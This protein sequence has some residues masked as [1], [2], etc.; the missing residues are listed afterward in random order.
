L[1]FTFL[2]DGEEDAV[3]WTYGMLQRQARVI[4]ARIQSS[5]PIDGPVLLLYP[6]GLDFIAAFAGC[7]HAG[8]IAVPAYPPRASRNLLRLKT[9]AFDSRARV[10][11]TTRQTLRRMQQLFKDDSQLG[12]LE[13]ICT[14]ELSHDL[15]AHWKQPA[16]SGDST[17]FLQYTSGSTSEPKGVAVSHSNLLCNEALIRSAFRQERRSVI[18]GWLPLYHDMGLI[19]NVFQPLYAAARAILMSPVAFVQRPVRWLRAISRYRAT[20]SGGPNFSYDL[21]TRR[22][23]QEEES[24]LDLSNW[25]VAFNGAEPVRSDTLNRFA[26]RFGKIGFNPKAFVPCYGLAE[27][28]LMVSGQTRGGPRTLCLDANALACNEVERTSSKKGITIVGCGKKVPRSKLAIVD[29]ES[30]TRCSPNR[31]GEI[32]IA[33]PS[34]AQGYWNRDEESQRTF[35]ARIAN[36]GE[37]PFLRTGDLGFINKDELFITGRLKDLI[38]I[39]GR[40]HYPRDIE[41]TV[42]AAHASLRPGCGAAFSVEANGE[43]QLVIVQ[44]V[45]H[46]HA[47]KTE[48]AVDAICIALMEQHEIQIHAI[49]LIRSG[50]IAKTSSGKIQRY[51]CREQFLAGTLN[52]ILEWRAS[53]GMDASSVISTPTTSVE[54]EV[55]LVE[56]LAR[57]AGVKPADIQSDVAMARYGLDSLGAIEFVY[58]IERELNIEVSS[59]SLL[60]GSSIHDYAE[61]LWRQVLSKGRSTAKN[62]EVKEAD[63]AEQFALTQNQRSLWFVHHL[64][65]GSAAYNLAF[66]ARTSAQLNSRIFEN[67]LREVVDRHPSL[68]TTFHQAKEEVI[69]RVHQTTETFVR[70]IDATSWSDADLNRQL[71]EEAAFQFNLEQGPLLRVALFQCAGSVSVICL[72]LHHIIADL[73]SLALLMHELT[74]LY[75]AKIAARPLQLPLPG[76]NYRDYAKWQKEEVLSAAQEEQLFSYWSRELGGELTILNLPT[77]QPRPPVQTYA[78]ARRSFR[79]SAELSQRIKRLSQEK[80][81]TPYMTLLATFQVLLS[82]YSGQQDILIGSPAAARNRVRWSEVVGYFVNP[83]VLRARLH[84][85][86]AFSEF[87]TQVRTAVLGALENQDYP[88]LNLVQRLQIE[89]DPSRSPLFQAM[90]VFE[91][92]LFLEKEGISAFALAETG[93]QVEFNG[94]ALEPIPL[95]NR[96]ALFDL[97]LM[98]SEIKGAFCGSF[99][100]NTDLF[101]EET[102]TRMVQHL[103]QLLLA[104]V[105]SPETTVGHLPMLTEAEQKQVLEQMNGMEE[106][107]SPLCIQEMFQLQVEQRP[108]AIAV[109]FEEQSL[110]YQELNSRANQLGHFLRGCGID[111]E[112]P[113]A[114]CCA[115][116][117]E[118]I[119]G[120]SGIL[121]AGGVHVPLD[122]AYPADRL[123]WML[124]DTEAP[125]LLTGQQT[126]LKFSETPC[127]RLRLDT[128]WKKITDA[129]TANPPPSAVPKNLAYIIYTSGSTG[130]PKGVAVS[131]AGI[132]AL[133]ETQRQNLG[134]GP[135]SRVLQFSSVSFDACI[136]EIV[137][138][139]TS[140]AALIVRPEDARG[141]RVLQDEM[142]RQ[143]VTHATL[144]P[145]VLGTLEQGDNL[146]SQCLIVAGEPCS[147][148][149]ASRWSKHR[150]MVNAYGPTET[151]VCATMSG[152]LSAERIPPIGSPILNTEVYVLD[153]RMEAVPVGIHG[154]L[155]IGGISL[156][157]GYL[158]QPQLTAEKFVPSP[159]RKEEGARLYRTGDLGR[160]RSDGNLEFIGRVDEQVK[161]RGHRVEPGEIESALLGNKGVRQ[162]VVVVREESGEKRLVAYWVRRGEGQGPSVRQLR[163]HLGE[164]LPD[165]MIPSAFVRLEDLPLTPNGK[166]DRKRLPAPECGAGEGSSRVASHTPVEEIMAGIWAEVLKVESVSAEADFFELGGHSLLAMQVMLRTR[167]AFGVNLPLAALFEAPTVQELAKRVEAGLRQGGKAE[168]PEIVPVSSEMP[169]P[170]SFAQQRLWFLHQVDPQ[171]IAYNGASALR[172]NGVL[173]VAALERAMSEIVRRHETL[174]TIFPAADGQPV[175]RI[176]PFT[177]LSVPLV[178]LSH[179]SEKELAARAVAD[180]EAERAFDLAQGP[181]L[182]IRLVRLTPDDHLLLV[183]MHHI[184]SDG[185][186]IGI[187]IREFT[188]L[189]EAFLQGQPSPLEDLAIQYADFAHWQREWMTGEVLEAQLAFW[190]GQLSGMEQLELPADYPRPVAALG[191]G[192]RLGIQIDAELKRRLEDVSRQQGVTLFMTLM[193]GFQLLL[194]RY[195]GQADVTVGTAIANRTCVETEPLIGFFVNTLVLRSCLRMEESFLDLLGQV[196]RTVLDAYAHQNL[197]FDRLV[198]ELAPERMLGQT[199]LFQA[200]LVLQNTPREQLRLPGLTL[201][202]WD[203]GLTA[204]TIDLRLAFTPT[205]TGLE[206]TLEYA[207]D[208]F[209]PERME[210]LARHF[211]KLLERAIG[212]PETRLWEISLLDEPE[213]RQVVE[214][215]NQTAMECPAGCV[216]NMFET[217]VET[218]PGDVALVFGDN[219]LTYAELNRRANRMAH[220]LRRLGIGPEVRV[221]ISLDRSLEIMVAILAVLKAGGAYVP[222]DPRYPTERLAYMLEDAGVPVLLTQERVAAT[223]PA[224]WCQ[225]LCVESLAETLEG[226]QETNP[227]PLARAENAAYVI[228]TSGSTGRPKGVVIHHRGACNLTIAQQQMFDVHPGDRVLQFFSF[229][230][231]ASVSEWTMALLNGGTLVLGPPEEWL[232]GSVLEELLRRQKITHVTLPPSVLATTPVS[233]LKELQTLVVAGEACPLELVKRCCREMRMLNAYGPT[234]VTVCA[235]ISNPL[236]GEAVPIGR[237]IANTE[238]YVLDGSMGPVPVGIA[239]ELYVGGIGLARGYLNQPDLTAEK[240]RPDLYSRAAGGQ[241]YRTGDK[242]RWRPDGQLEYLGRIDQ[243]VKIRGFRI[244]LG[245]IE[246]TLR[247]H[248]GIGEAVVVPRE[249]PKGETR[250]V[251]YVV[252][253]TKPKLVELWPSVAEYFVYDDLL[254]GAMVSDH[255]R[256][257]AYQSAFDR[258]VRD[259][260]VVD[261]G[262]GPEAI[263]ARLCIESGARTVYAIE[264]LKDSYERAAARV[265]SLGLENRIVLLHGDARTMELPEAADVCVS[266]IVGPIGG[267]EGAGPILNSARRFLKPGGIM[268]PQ[269]SVTRIAAVELPAELKGN[270]GFS[271]TS[272]HYVDRIFD[273]IGKQFDLR[274]CIKDFPKSSVLSSSDVFE[275][276]DFS[277]FVE[278]ESDRQI[279]LDLTKS[280][281]LDGLLAWLTL[282]TTA[283]TTID[284]LEHEHCWLPVFFPLFDIGI[285]VDP[286]DRIEAV[287]RSR[288]CSNQ[289]N[290]DYE[291]EGTVLRKTGRN[292]PFRLRSDHFGNGFRQTAFYRELF[293]EGKVKISDPASDLHIEDVRHYLQQNLPEYMLPSEFVALPELPLTPNGKLDRKALPAPRPRGRSY[294]EQVTQTPLQEILAGIWIEVLG[295]DQV[296]IHDSFFELGGHSLLATQVISRLQSTL[297]VELPVRALFESPTIAML[298]ERLEHALRQEQKVNVPAI[299]PVAR[300]TRMPLSFAQQRLWFIHQLDPGNAAYNVPVAVWLRGDL[301]Y[302]SVERSLSEIV[303]R[304]EILRTVFPAYEGEPAQEIGEAQPLP[305]RIIDLEGLE[306]R[307]REKQQEQLTR[308]EARRGF[309]L[310]QGPLLRVT[311]IRLEERQHVLLVTMHH[312]VSDGWSTRILVRE[313]SQLYEAYH[314]RNGSPLKELQI[315]YADFAVWQRAL[316]RGEILESQL[317]YWKKQL[318]GVE[319]L[320][321]PTDHVR[322][323]AATQRGRSVAFDLG[324]DLAQQLRIFSRQEGATLF[325]TLLAAFQLLLCRYSGRY[326]FV[327]GVPIA[328]RNR[329]ETEGLVGFFINHLAVRCRLKKQWTFGDLLREVREITLGAYAHQDLPFE[330]LVEELAPQRSLTQ[331]PLFQVR[332]ALQNTPR[333][334]LRLADLE[335]RIIGGE[336]ESVKSDLSLVMEENS[337]GLSGSLGYATDLFEESTVQRMVKHFQRILEAAIENRTQRIEAFSFLTETEHRQLLE[338]W[339]SRWQ[340]EQTPDEFVHQ[341]FENQVERSP[342][343][344]ALVFEGQTLTYAELN[345]RA[346]RLAQ[347]LRGL[348]IG[349]ELRVGICMERSLEM[350]VGVL[351]VLKAGGAYVPLDADLPAERLGGMLE[352]A[353]VTL[354]L[355]QSRLRDRLPVCWAQVIDMD[356]EWKT[357]EQEGEERN[358]GAWVGGANLAYVI[359]TSGSTGTPKGVAIE[360]RQISSYVKAVIERLEMKEN[361]S[362]GLISTFAADL[363]NTMLFPSLCVGGTLHVIREDHGRDGK[364]LRKY[365]K[366]WGELDCL[367]ITPTHLRA[368]VTSGG[369]GLLPRQRLVVGGEATAWEW[370]QEWQANRP[371]CQ[372]WNHYGPTECTVGVCTYATSRAAANKGGMRGN[373]PLGT[374]LRHSRMYVLDDN[375]GLAPGGIP[376][377]LYIGGEG[378]GRGY[379]NGSEI[380]AERFVPDQYGG[381]P[382]KRLYRTG[383][384]VRWRQNGELE[385]L[386]RMD[387]QIKLRGYRVELGEIEHLLEEHPGVQQSAVMVRE[388]DPGEQRL[389]AYFVPVGHRNI[390]GNNGASRYRLPNGWSLAHQNRN[391][392]EYLYREIFENQIYFQHGIELQDDA[393]V[394]DVGANIGMFTLFVSTRCSRGRIFAFEPIP[395]I[396]ECLK[397]N[398]ELCDTGIKIFPVGLSN[399]ERTAEFTYY[400]R[401][402]MMSGLSSYANAGEELETIQRTLRNQE[403]AGDQEAHEL[404]IHAEK[405]LEGRF[406][407]R[408]KTCHLRRLS[409]VIREEGVQ[410]IDV[411]KID[412]QRAELDVLRG[413][414]APDWQKI[415]QIVMEVHDGVGQKTEGRLREIIRLLEEKGFY[416]CAEHY[417]ELRGTDRWNLYASRKEEKERR[418]GALPVTT[419]GATNGSEKIQISSGELS[420]GELR[421][422]LAA[423]LPDYMVPAAFVELERLPLMANGKLDRQALPKPEDTT[424]DGEYVGPRTLVEEILAGIW[425]EVLKVEQVGGESNFFELGGHSLLATQVI[426]RIEAAFGVELPLRML[427][428]SPTVAGLAEHLERELRE[429][430]QSTVP[431]MVPV[432]RNHAL[433]LSFAQQRMWFL[434]QL[435]PESAVYNLPYALRF[436]GD[437]DDA[438]LEYALNEIVCRQE[439]LRTR[440]ELLNGE[441]VQRIEPAAAVRVD[442]M[443]LT[444]MPDPEGEARRLAEKEAASPFELSGSPLLR[445]R[446]LRLAEHDHVLLLTLHHIASD[447]WS[448][449]ILVREFVAFYR[450]AVTGDGAALTELS[451]QY[452][453]FAVWQREW[454]R[455]EAL[456]SQIDWWQSRL[457]DLPVLNLAL[458]RRRPAISSYH[459]ALKLFSLPELLVSNLEFVC[460]SKGATM[461]M[462]LAAVFQVLMG[463]YAG[464]TDVVLGTEIAGRNRLVL[465]PLIG[466]F[467]NQL[468]LRVDLSGQ[469]SF[470]EVL[471]RVREMALGAYMH[472]DLPFEKLVEVLSPKRDLSVAPLFQVKLVLQNLPQ[473][474]L[475]L[476]GVRL[477]PF[478]I[479]RRFSQLDLTLIVERTATG[480]RGGLEYST[481]LFTPQTIERILQHFQTLLQAA[482]ENPERPTAEIS[483]LSK[484]ERR[485]IME[486]WNDTH[487][488][489]GPECFHELFELQARHTPDAIAI[490][491]QART[492][493]YGEL[494]V[495]ANR[496]A[497]YLRKLGVGP[498]AV[499]GLCMERGAD[500]AIAIMGVLKSGAAWLPLNPLYPVGRLAHILR[501]AHATILITQD[502]FRPADSFGGITVLC[503]DS[504]LDR[505]EAERTTNPLRTADPANLAYVTYTSGSTGGPK[506]VMIEQ[507]G[508]VNHL[509]AKI[510]DL[511]LTNSDVVAQNAVLSFDISV[512]Q[513]LAVLA[514]GGQVDV[515]DDAIAHDGSQLLAESARREITVLETVPALLSAIVDHQLQLNHRRL[516]LDKLRVLISNAEALPSSVVQSWSQ[517]YPHIPLK[518]TYGA[519]ECSDDVAHYDTQ[520]LGDLARSYAPLG[521]PLRNSKLYVLDEL[522]EPVP[523]GIPGEV[524][525]G[526]VCVGR[527]YLNQPALTAERFLPDPFGTGASQRLYRTGDC[528]RWLAEGELEFLGRLDQQVKVRGY[529]IEPGEIEAVLIQHSD[530]RHSAVILRE[531]EAGQ[532]YL[533]AYVVPDGATPTIPDLRTLVSEKLPDYMVPSAFVMMSSLPLTANGKLDRRALPEPERVVGK[534]DEGEELETGAERILGGIWAQVLRVDR[535]GGQDNFFELGGDS[536]LSIKVVAR[537]MQAGLEI[538]VQQMFQHQRLRELA[539]VAR[540]GNRREG[541]EEEVRG[542]VALTAIQRWF[543]EQEAEAGH[544]FN[545]ALLLK[546]RG[547]LDAGRLGAAVEAVMKHHEG[548]RLRY[549][550]EVGGGW[551]QRY[552]EKHEPVFTQID[553]GGVEGE[554]QAELMEEICA[555]LQRSLDLERGPLARVAYFEWGEGRGGRLLWVMHHLIVDG[556]SW[557]ILLED[558]HTA[559]QQLEAGGGVMLP[560]RTMSL[561]K[562]AEGLKEWTASGALEEEAGFWL[563]LKERKVGRLPRD[564][565]GGSN[566][567]KGSETVVRELGEKETMALL[568]QAPRRYQTQMQDVLLTALAATVAEWTGEEGVL[569]EMEGHGREA[570]QGDANVTRTVGW[571]TTHF[572]VWLPVRQGMDLER[573]MEAVRRAM[574]AVPRHGIG[575]GL[576]RYVASNEQMREELSALPQAEISFNYLGQ[577]DE[578]LPAESLFGP[579]SEGR[580]PSQDERQK[581]S[582]PLT[583]L[584]SISD[585]KLNVGWDFNRELHRWETVE[586]LAARFMS[587]LQEIANLCHTAPP[588]LSPAD[589]PMAKLNSEQLQS[590]ARKVGKQVASQK[591]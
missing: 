149:L 367:K 151:T 267:V 181:L 78:G 102:V 308:W 248:A 166:I 488:A 340:A 153:Q 101:E 18:V 90:F 273:Q 281:R 163:S 188:A 225:V 21:C 61:Q 428:E 9:I 354:L 202:G 541:A 477:V 182:R 261:V 217:Q 27:A 311:V 536:I 390:A 434:H 503:L 127:R 128:D 550:R 159:F 548:V 502:K 110:T 234:E 198:E 118:L 387:G 300:E 533:V 176:I 199:P 6:A 364:D 298:A 236:D 303:R 439:I 239:G 280:G 139:L 41:A 320:D 147:G 155:Y 136:W 277:G 152:P 105:D 326:D 485:Q 421:G 167:M 292:V 482:V 565:E 389:V 531:D 348:G 526:G 189:Y 458:D 82:R 500:V 451:I 242:A 310:N 493:S 497:H 321:L 438:A 547:P 146:I 325:M 38:I 258:H 398:V 510:E 86:P 366:E 329:I 120:V 512:W 251:A 522:G 556:V 327:I 304:H 322:P 241:L 507:L 523:I 257:Q 472:Q 231:D 10:A 2:N 98:M 483:L 508:M 45:E 552:A 397:S 126:D 370:A 452:A 591:T 243:Q 172:L 581:R 312:I 89:R 416:A 520:V 145:S 237:P 534:G 269:R 302:E 333:E 289:L 33:G 210:R 109:V 255:R 549:W 129:S 203:S 519:T 461:F 487:V 450:A 527:G 30:L 121:K 495:N 479:E 23:T 287:C 453:D 119:I 174:R 32:W 39:R 579:A 135:N 425:C 91:K 156:A 201:K 144:P 220:Y 227:V 423:K 401:Y 580:G 168:I 185:W 432:D 376:G 517:C 141:G 48:D 60:E 546:A 465:E 138:A 399:E 272:A 555:A 51:I 324:E 506:G 474:Q 406:E 40:N 94:L 582:H 349:P 499:V 316:L 191:R 331:A 337:S 247:K 414:D 530:V 573:G 142:V 275:D 492:F 79:L 283:G 50:S 17:A 62:K 362:Y 66:A 113:V 134:I 77:D 73:W 212:A 484:N 211:V 84:G 80:G 235:T 4:A 204:I 577:L 35:C 559:W 459:G 112:T 420:S 407:A 413:I 65:P 371:E 262:T 342:S 291:I 400:S 106:T 504:D 306:E 193:A 564:Y 171:S 158:K 64:D 521:K 53:S 96:V 524:Y 279:R 408:V 463:R 223:M 26:E 359:Y 187:L 393:C 417:D 218:R 117:L 557:R 5:N 309:D 525:I 469:P 95:Q 588:K 58:E 259:K 347:Y 350:V 353:Q 411:L 293:P 470:T 456:Q 431:P 252:N 74:L 538:T 427:F 388:D 560:G 441:A 585:G 194:G 175:Q 567:I 249:D 489:A 584:A 122:P 563:G 360:H 11:L 130:G 455:D 12:A 403:E 511:K 318:E 57:K 430:Q 1:A 274:V 566:S 264:Y 576:L 253:R 93:V 568:R 356:I 305:L 124:S 88:F 551:R 232:A 150:C 509:L 200:L 501:D 169:L 440:Y 346:D 154:E 358:I 265:R 518:N 491:D 404:L 3:D 69:Q 14:D 285:S 334:E 70:D 395:E 535:V 196:R 37:G 449:S 254:Y 335:L 55:W 184:I 228:Y 494:N 384:R 157:R 76:F 205:D 56:T 263:L 476:P 418:S 29:P 81:A 245:E 383:D 361:W 357:I 240:F 323:V 46:A 115:R 396:F 87:L 170:L 313:F 339:N 378:V 213:W 435:E 462:G 513:L 561:Q 558:L 386:G 514:V 160:W 42:E 31:V 336:Q 132:S 544:H 319:T 52:T 391:E 571:F 197:P 515:I 351:G 103:E 365:L 466:F 54:L 572:P 216:H 284:I 214:E 374:P 437:L 20:T 402:S 480:M 67:A 317:R 589:F 224:S 59:S 19:G 173:D 290:P 215:W 473:T 352:D 529:R 8:V 562:W 183:T 16:V 13:F 178:D 542:E 190:R 369:M 382:G 587:T 63:Q 415:R 445:V 586:G 583:V 246:S 341:L 539:A 288:L 104:I 7:I 394:F 575:Y 447:G 206:G 590:I 481:D 34:V 307:E 111:A 392:T 114:I 405:L 429:G 532:K 108:D 116:S 230:F 97:T 286:D 250:L 297:G 332:F 516:K 301:D 475:D 553:L 296:G 373:V 471:A 24:G 268:I 71:E 381:S 426:S 195:C 578:A 363:G 543:F 478:Q 467:V 75:A 444:N 457:S 123:R 68:R 412:V 446:L 85:N 15:A 442:R 179:V 460:R 219:H 433:P 448:L 419:T 92:T 148:E 226:E 295:L 208:L 574:A 44:E 36:T 528:G 490:R 99:Q 328:N 344:I 137:M 464:T 276:L 271:R 443:D 162:A 260:V 380:T 266:E 338:E 256:N 100:Y 554:K 221:G 570:V 315:Q 165:Y 207:S 424:A 343:R 186:S 468:A 22:I 436:N 454:L 377:E 107:I 278:L 299:V 192:R 355:T 422:Y 375:G 486:T 28:T 209:A 379:L 345:R 47:Q 540:T 222:L 229:S 180:A 133:V 314:K 161:V 545:Q 270:P 177:G 330:K 72:C 409:D 140:G 537:A 164:R 410:R 131:H 505:I 282:E 49:A 233:A 125:L 385:F 25:Q 238:V 372:I 244:E 498:E 143:S 368:L 43:E 496:L 569:V 83:V 294:E